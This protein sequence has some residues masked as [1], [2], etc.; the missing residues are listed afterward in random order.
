MISAVFEPME[1]SFAS[2]CDLWCFVG[3][4]AV[5]LGTLGL[6]FVCG[7][8]LDFWLAQTRLSGEAPN[9]LGHPTY[10][11]IALL[12]LLIALL[13]WRMATRL[14]QSPVTQH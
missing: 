1:G 2:R 10:W 14:L 9:V 8:R 12:R 3:T 7:Y 6:F 11:Y 5:F 4:I 13:A